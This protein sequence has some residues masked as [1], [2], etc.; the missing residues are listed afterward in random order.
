MKNSGEDEETKKL[1]DF[2]DVDKVYVRKDI[3]ELMVHQNIITD[4]YVKYVDE[5]D[6]SYLAGYAYNK[7]T[8]FIIINK[9][10]TGN[11]NY[12]KPLNSGEAWTLLPTNPN[13]DENGVVDN[14]YDVLAGE[15]NEDE[16]G[17]I[18][19]VDN[20]NRIYESALETLGLD[21]KEVTFEDI[22]N[23]ELKIILNDD[24]YIDNNGSFSPNQDLETLYNNPNS[25]TVKVKAIIR[26]K[27]DNKTITNSSGF[28]Y[29]NALSELVIEHNKNSKIVAAQRDADYNILTSAP[30]D[31]TVTKNIMLGYLGDDVTPIMIYL[32]PKDFDSKEKMIDYLDKYNEDKDDVDKIEY[33]DMA[34]M[35]SSLS[36]GIMDAITI[37]LIA[38]SSISLIVS[39]IMIG[40]ITY[41]SVLERT[42]EI[43]ILRSLGARS[44][45]IKR[46]F[47]AET[48]IIGITSGILGI[49]I[50]RLLII[51][52]NQVIYNV[53]TLKNVAKMSIMH[54]TVLILVS[55]TL[56]IIGGYIPAK[57]AAKKNPVEALRSE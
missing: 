13:K 53:S 8:N 39:S 7:G 47:I 56:T 16:V 24:Y 11:Y 48:F 9:D 57:I 27:E 4:E 12:V 46:V 26:G 30:F 31:E 54:T 21:G 52:I 5:M 6:K 43:G 51:P 38:F 40:I 25:I 42:K 17:L 37:V 28:A 22:M 32:Y 29:T 14:M 50:A 23:A 44:K 55:T 15:I 49:L 41:I 1:K 35:I 34:G 20:K 10:Y 45:D 36:G 2:P 33:T 18:L 19:Q 3:L